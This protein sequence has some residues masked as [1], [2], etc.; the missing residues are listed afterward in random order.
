M[1]QPTLLMAR[2]DILNGGAGNDQ[3]IGG[4]GVDRVRGGTGR[5]TFRIQRGTGYDIIEDFTNGQ[6]R[7]QLGS[8]SSGLRMNNQGDDVLIYQGADL[9]ARVRCSGRYSN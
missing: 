9:L 3:L 7:I 2:N 1:L 4:S 8:G 5:D 6:D